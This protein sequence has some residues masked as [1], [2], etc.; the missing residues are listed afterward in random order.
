VGGFGMILQNRIEFI[1]SKILAL[2]YSS[3]FGG[4][5]EK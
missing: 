4:Y 5:F 2:I 3:S 1:L